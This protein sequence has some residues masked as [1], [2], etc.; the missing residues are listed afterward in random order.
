MIMFEIAIIYSDIWIY[1]LII[2]AVLQE[3]LNPCI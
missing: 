2:L 3:K 1:L